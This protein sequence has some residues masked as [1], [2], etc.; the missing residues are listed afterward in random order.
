LGYYYK[1]IYFNINQYEN[2]IGYYKHIN[3]YIIHHE[4]KLGYYKCDGVYWLFWGIL[5]KYDKKI[6]VPISLIYFSWSM[7]KK[8]ICA[9]NILIYFHDVWYKNLYV[10]QIAKNTIV[11]DFG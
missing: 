8:N 2:K 4:N 6:S 9:C 7:I 5:I 3:F 11:L 1:H 10:L